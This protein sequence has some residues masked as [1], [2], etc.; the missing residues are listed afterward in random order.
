MSYNSLLTYGDFIPLKVTCNVNKL[1]E[2]GATVHLM[3]SRGMIKS[4][5]D[6]KEAEEYMRSKTEEQ[7][8]EWGVKYHRLYFGKPRVDLYVDDRGVNDMDFFK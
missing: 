3:T 2:E 4:E 1:F 5:G 7:L 8:R 6:P